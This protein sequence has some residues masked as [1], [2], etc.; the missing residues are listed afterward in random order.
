MEIVCLQTIIYLESRQYFRMQSNCLRLNHIQK[1][2]AQQTLRCSLKNSEMGNLRNCRISVVLFVNGITENI[3]CPA[4]P[5]IDFGRCRG[6]WLPFWTLPRFVK[7]VGLKHG[8]CKTNC[9][10]NPDVDFCRIQMMCQAPQNL[11]YLQEVPDLWTLR[12][13][14]DSEL[15]ACRMSFENGGLSLR[16]AARVLKSLTP[17]VHGFSMTS[18]C[19]RVRRQIC[20][21]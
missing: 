9:P 11:D 7:F 12:K 5:G 10:A 14:K 6:H 21:L 3:I 17:W 13:I 15:E 19:P 4:N 20:G 16:K 1:Q 18:H 2:I 8:M